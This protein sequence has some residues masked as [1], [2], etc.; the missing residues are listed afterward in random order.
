MPFSSKANI[1]TIYP[2]WGKDLCLETNLF[3]FT[4]AMWIKIDIQNSEM[5]KRYFPLFRFTSYPL[6]IS[7]SIKF[8]QQKEYRTSMTCDLWKNP[9]SPAHF[10][11]ALKV[12][13]CIFLF[14]VQKCLYFSHQTL[15]LSNYFSIRF[16]AKLF[17]P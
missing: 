10:P 5:H 17:I 11:K 7:I 2:L 15:W 3:G 14:F 9:T 4:E 8:S 6:D 16:W 13:M 12:G 1:C